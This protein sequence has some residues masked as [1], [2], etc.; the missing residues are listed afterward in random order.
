MNIKDAKEIYSQYSY[1]SVLTEDEEFML[2]EAMR[3]LVEKTG[4]TRWMTELGGY[5]YELR[6]FDLALKYYELADEYGD[7][8]AP[9]GLGYIWYYGRT[10]QRDYEKAF[11][12]YSKAAKNGQIKSRIKLADMYKNGYFVEKDY[13]KYCSMIEDAYDDVKDADYLNIPKPEVFTRLAKIRKEQGRTGEAV[14]LYIDAKAFLA[15][16]IRFDPFF[17][18]LNIMKWLIEDLYTMIPVDTALIDLFDLYFL[19]KE[20]AKIE[21]MYDGESYRVES[22]SEDDGLCIRFGDKWFQTIDDFFLKAVIDDR[23]VVVMADELY[24]FEVR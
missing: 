22:V 8:W 15:Q 4:D 13:D 12:Y 17:G 20:P 23:R 6:Q 2:I 19:L 3:F 18:D 10:G 24:A 11:H 1:K 7:E 9:E 5:Y 21:F 14:D 16:R